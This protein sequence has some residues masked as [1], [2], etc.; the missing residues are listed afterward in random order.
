MPKKR[1][2]SAART[3]NLKVAREEKARKRQ[4]STEPNSDENEETTSDDEMVSVL[5]IPDLISE[6][7]FR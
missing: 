5:E 3:Q 4:R 6:H 2:Y 7:H 1:N